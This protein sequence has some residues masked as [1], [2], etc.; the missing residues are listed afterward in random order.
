MY[1]ECNYL[2]R[3]I[4]Q[5]VIGDLLEA[6]FSL[7]VNDGEETTLTHSKDML[8]ITQAM[9]S[10][11]E[12]YLLV[13]RPFGQ[14]RHFGWVRL[15]HGNGRDIISDYTVNLETCLHGANAFVEMLEAA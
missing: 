15:I 10:T 13:Y 14:E 5:R 1:H 9:F 8:Q 3:I 6:G 4:V 11:D 12:D 7:G 2:E